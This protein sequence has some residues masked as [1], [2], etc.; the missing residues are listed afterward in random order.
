MRHSSRYEARLLCAPVVEVQVKCGFRIASCEA[1]SLV[2]KLWA[3]CLPRCADPVAGSSDRRALTAAR[4]SSRSG[5]PFATPLSTEVK[6]V[7][8]PSPGTTIT[9][10]PSV[11]A[12]GKVSS[13][14]EP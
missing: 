7:T 12:E 10:N 3:V 13:P 2:T 14:L 9:S 5:Y 11:E 4:G 6:T 8:S 1:T